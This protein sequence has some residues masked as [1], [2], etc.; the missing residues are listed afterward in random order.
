MANNDKPIAEEILAQLFNIFNM[1]EI[2]DV[3]IFSH[4]VIDSEEILEYLLKIYKHREDVIEE[5]LKYISN[6]KFVYCSTNIDNIFQLFEYDIDIDNIN[7]EMRLH[8]E[9][10]GN[11]MTLIEKIELL[12]QYNV[13]RNTEIETKLIQID[14]YL[15]NYQEFKKYQKKY[16]EKY[17]ELYQFINNYCLKN[18][19]NISNFNIINN[20]SIHIKK[21]LSE[22]VNIFY[23]ELLDISNLLKN[24]LK[25]INNEIESMN[26]IF[27]IKEYMPK[28][29]IKPSRPFY[30]LY[31]K[32]RKIYNLNNNSNETNNINSFENNIHNESSNRNKLKK[33]NILKKNIT[34]YNKKEININ[35]K[36]SCYKE[37]NKESDNNCNYKCDE[38]K[39]D[40]CNNFNNCNHC[41]HCNNCNETRKIEKEYVNLKEIF[42]KHKFSTYTKQFLKM[43]SK[44]EYLSYCECGI[45]HTLDTYNYPKPPKKV[46]ELFDKIKKI[47]TN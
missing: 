1:T 47:K 43:Q 24:I 11:P 3:D 27:K 6:D 28:K 4:K 46:L 45:K 19:K 32:H 31:S 13:M 12:K 40:Y 23:K 15:N 22:T 16:Q 36:Y 10:Y 26:F 35:D 39:I 34:E 9:L 41:N 14:N 33:D 18:Y 25:K 17:N 20:Y 21:T 5:Y 38:N 42:E 37:L 8:N 44:Q 2:P 7:F 30:K 29:D